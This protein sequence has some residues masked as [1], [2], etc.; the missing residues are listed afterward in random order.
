MFIHSFEVPSGLYTTPLL[1]CPH[2]MS[3][4]RVCVCVCVCVCVLCVCVC[5]KLVNAEALLGASLRELAA[6]VKLQCTGSTVYLAC[7]QSNSWFYTYLAYVWFASKPPSVQKSLLQLL[8]YNRHTTQR[9]A[10]IRTTAL[11]CAHASGASGGSK[12]RMHR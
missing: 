12:V 3:L 11:A 1:I 6:V 8:P 10:G 7:I 5:Q 4:L 9:C 2:P